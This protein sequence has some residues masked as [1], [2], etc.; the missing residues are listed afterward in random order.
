MCPRPFSHAVAFLQFIFAE[1]VNSMLKK[2][3][4]FKSV[5]AQSGKSGFMLVLGLRL[6]PVPSYLCSYGAS[7]G[8]TWRGV[9]LAGR[10]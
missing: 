8:L 4:T 5:K 3:A 2:N 1:L 9:T 7:V 6:S 10:G